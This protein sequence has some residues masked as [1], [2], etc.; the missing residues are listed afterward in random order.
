MT[1]QKW[2]L[3]AIFTCNVLAGMRKLHVSY[4]SSDASRVAGIS[5][6]MSFACI[7]LVVTS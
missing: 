7:G 6:V 5:M 1:W 2:V 3:I 4:P